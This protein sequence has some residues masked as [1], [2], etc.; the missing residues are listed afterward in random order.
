MLAVR[1]GQLI[2]L[3]SLRGDVPLAEYDDIAIAAAVGWGTTGGVA[4]L[5]DGSIKTWGQFWGGVAELPEGLDGVIALDGGELNMVALRDDG[6]VISFPDVTINGHSLAPPAGLRDVSKIGVG[7]TRCFALKTD[8][9]VVA[10]GEVEV[11]IAL[12]NVLDLSVGEGGYDLFLRTDGTVF[13]LKQ[14]GWASILDSVL[15][16]ENLSGVTAVA[17]G[18]RHGMALKSDGTIEVWGYFANS[19]AFIPENLTDV[20]EIAANENFCAALLED[21]SVVIWGEGHFSKTMVVPE[22]FVAASKLIPGRN[23]FF[24]ISAPVVT[25]YDTQYEV[26]AG[27]DFALSIPVAPG[28]GTIVWRKDGVIILGENR[29]TL[30]LPIV[31]LNDAGSYIAD[32]SSGGQT[33][34]FARTDVRVEAGDGSSAYL[35]NISARG[36]AGSDTDAMIAGFV[37]EGNSARSLL[38]RGVGPTLANFGLDGVLADPRISLTYGGTQIAS[39]D[40]WADSTGRSY[41]ETYYW[42]GAFALP[43]TSLDSVLHLNLSSGGYTA[44]LSS[45]DSGTGIALV[46]CY[47]ETHF[48]ER[49]NLRVGGNITGKLVNISTRARVGTGDQALIGGFVVSGSGS[50]RL[51]IRGVG[52]ELKRSYGIDS[53]IEGARVRLFQQSVLVK[54]NSSWSESEEASSIAQIAAQVGAFS[55]PTGSRDAALLVELQPGPY[56]VILDSA[57]GETG[58]GIVEIYEVD[59]VQ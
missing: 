50:Q 33:E 27:D 54:S 17:A 40:N 23:R 14:N 29:P 26:K 4:V 13:D 15:M 32:V 51:L 18:Y 59:F 2:E 41:E 28:N 24:A 52:P 25:N 10:W 56:T 37:V 55:L 47:D 49:N 39:N 12:E 21:Q 35:A 11:P 46:E 9:S 7:R 34:S 43:E 19:L 16:P 5:G 58:I 53:A 6:T 8:G 3:G 38:I 36:Q 30:E 1:P 44:L 48:I 20:V 22:N 42:V 31:Q 45:K 57:E